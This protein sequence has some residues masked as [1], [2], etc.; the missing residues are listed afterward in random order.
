MYKDFGR[1]KNET[2]GLRVLKAKRT[3][4]ADWSGCPCLFRRSREGRRRGRRSRR[5]RG[6][7]PDKRGEDRL[8]SVIK[9]QGGRQL[10][11]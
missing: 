2:G 9:P 1:V 7:G 4:L 10:K 3:H 6:R 8:M 11:A 5:R